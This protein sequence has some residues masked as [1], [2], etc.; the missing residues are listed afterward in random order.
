MYAPVR[1]QGKGAQRIEKETVARCTYKR[2]SRWS[3]KRHEGHDKDFGKERPA[4]QTEMP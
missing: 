1:V 4:A 3:G 2:G